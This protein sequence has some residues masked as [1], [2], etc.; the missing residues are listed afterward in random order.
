MV[1]L[2]TLF[3]KQ[4]IMLVLALLLTLGFLFTSL[5]SYQVSK[6]TI[7]QSI[8]DRELP[9][10]SDNI[11]SEIQK[12]LIRPVFVSSMMASDT[13]LRDWVVQGELDVGSITRYLTEVRSR[14]GA[15]TA[16]FVSE[17]SGNY[18]HPDGR[19][20]R[21]SPNDPR[22]AWYYRV[23]AQQA[24]YEINVDPDEAHRDTLTIFVNY[25]VLD[26]D[27]HF[28]G[29]AGVGLTVDAVRKLI[30]E[31]Q[32]KYQRNVYFVDRSGKIVL[33]GKNAPLSGTDIKALPGLSDIA[34]Q[35]L[36]T[37]SGSYEYWADGREHL[38]NTRFVPELEWYLFVEK[39]ADEDLN[40]VRHILGINLAISAGI[41]LLI[42]LLARFTITRYQSRLEEMATVDGL[43]G[44]FNHQACELLL[45]QAVKE[46]RRQPEASAVLLMDIDH[47]KAIND[48]HGHLAGDR[49][50]EQVARLTRDTVREMDIAGRW[51]GDEFV[52]LL[53]SCDAAAAVATAEKLIQRAASNRFAITGGEA[54][55]TLSI[56][57]AELQKDDT[58]ENALTRADQALYAAK[59]Q[60]RNRACVAPTSASQ[61]S[62][63]SAQN[64]L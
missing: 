23:R 37:P 29:V 64:Q 1:R 38:L 17:R 11:F 4:R 33:F 12:D 18:Y 27:G 49:V 36:Q 55:V 46:F 6:T 62:P 22:D 7:R 25:R 3:G 2:Q 31:Y 16:F 48:R 52:I 34:A 45:E 10:T 58:V 47:F 13:F 24:P 40:G 30:E 26:F 50:I 9:L 42:M 5:A 53:K 15:V 39:A 56:G 41:T 28:I 19:L 8:V 59:N 14:Y 21:V 32:E 57:I 35:A 51:G 20:K 54:E 63:E 43:T 60:G 44:L 61:G